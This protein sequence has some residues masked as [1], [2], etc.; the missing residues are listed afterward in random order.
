MRKYNKNINVYEAANERFDF[1][2]A[3][4]ERIYLSFSGGKD[5]GVMLNLILDYMKKNNIKKKI[6]V[7]VMDNEANYEYSL[8]FMY[9]I[10]D[11]NKEYLDIYWI[12]LPIT[13]PCT[14]S[15]YAVDW[16]CWGE[17]DKD[18]WIRPMPDKDYIVNIENHKFDFFKENMN[19]DE[20]WDEFGEWYS[21]GKRTACLIGIRTEESLNRFRAIMNLNKK[22]LKNK[23]WTKKNGDNVYNVY[24]IYDWK[25][26]DIWIANS[27]FEWDYNKLYDIFYKAGLTVNS[28]RVASPFMS[29]SKSSLGLYRVIDPNTWARLCSRVHGANFIATYGKQLNYNSIKLPEGHTWKSFVKFLLA[30]LPKEVSENF[31][32]RFVQS[33]RYWGRVGQ[34]V[35]DK[36]L[37]ELEGSPVKIK[38]NGL[39]PH[40]R[41]NKYRIVIKKYP[42]HTDFLSCNN[43][44]VAS[45]KRFALTILKN[46]HICK[47]M[48]FAQTKAQMDRQK[49]ITEK[50]KNL[51]KK[52]KANV[53]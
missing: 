45:W 30:T 17:S 38:K 50:Y 48:G 29:E 5:S 53:D 37:E 3:N 51:D 21:E 24:P 39:T 46:D 40:G 10:L 41:K 8:E 14:V 31:R 34:T 6:G 25:T 33:I 4:F 11:E 26:K 12:C 9:R 49:Q 15:S 13:L 16:Q 35:S 23:M 32:K 44:D 27:K 19:Y 47:Y 43:R 18:L 7:M 28:M 52:V 22:I 42:D 20:F 1:I 2:F 36:T